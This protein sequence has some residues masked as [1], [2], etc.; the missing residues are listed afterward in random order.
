VRQRRAVLAVAVNVQEDGVRQRERYSVTRS[1]E[2]HG[3]A[4]TVMSASA[5]PPR[6]GT[7]LST[8]Q[9]LTVSV[10]IG[11][12]VKNAW[13]PLIACATASASPPRAGRRRRARR[14]AGSRR[15]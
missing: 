10:T 14:C 5:L 8:M 7:R 11:P 13:C 2:I 9:P 1:T 15:C 3:A 12:V 4:L 6:A